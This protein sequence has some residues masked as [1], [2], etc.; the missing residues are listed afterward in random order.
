MIGTSVDDAELINA[1]ALTV[2]GA[3]AGDEL[4]VLLRRYRIDRMLLPLT[5]PLFGHPLAR[6]AKRSALPLAYLDWTEGRCHGAA[7][8][9]PIEPSLPAGDVV[10]RLLSWLE[11]GAS[12]RQAAQI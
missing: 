12:A 3:V 10:K 2:T 5:H 4:G 11:E 8:D 6:S 7:G 9:L 1:G